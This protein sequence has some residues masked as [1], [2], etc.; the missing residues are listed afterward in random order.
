VDHHIV[1]RRAVRVA[2]LDRATARLP[3]LDCTI[4]GAGDHPLALAVEGYACDVAR[5]ALEA[6][7]RVGVGRLDVVELDRVVAGRGQVTL[8]G[9]DA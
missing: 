4:L 9:G 6:E 2:S 8:I 5:V 3:D 1:D 7:Q